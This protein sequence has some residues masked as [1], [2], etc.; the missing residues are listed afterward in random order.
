MQ[1]WLPKKKLFGKYSAQ[2]HGGHILTAKNKKMTVPFYLI[3]QKSS[4]PP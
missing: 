3:S 2:E 1:Y 4:S